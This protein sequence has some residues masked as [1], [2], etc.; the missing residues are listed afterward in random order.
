MCGLALD[1]VTKYDLHEGDQIT[2]E[3]I[4]L[5]LLQEEKSKI[6][7]HAFRLLSYRDRSTREM[8]QRLIE[9][10]Y[11]KNLVNEVI[12]EFLSDNTLD[13][14]RFTRSFVH[15]YTNVKVKGNVFIQRELRRKGISADTIQA[16]LVS[17]DERH[18]ILN[19][20]A[21]KMADLDIHDPK[22]CQK[23]INRLLSRGFSSAVVYDVI[24]EQQLEHE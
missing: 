13:D 18:L 23:I 8:E 3:H 7:N 1:I 9:R 5:L 2:Q 22:Q 6:R 20:I 19:Y 24:S 17:R 4:D 21:R 14:E 16:A 12:E 11:D 15:D 10:G